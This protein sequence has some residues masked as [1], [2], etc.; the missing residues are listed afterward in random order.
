M[1]SPGVPA[2]GTQCSFGLQCVS[3]LHVSCVSEELKKVVAVSKESGANLPR[4]LALLF[5]RSDLALQER[6]LK[7]RTFLLI[8]CLF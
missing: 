1:A 8:L 4:A 7:V 6:I 5:L 3:C 2:L